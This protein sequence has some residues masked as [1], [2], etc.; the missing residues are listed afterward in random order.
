MRPRTRE[1][2][3]EDYE[4]YQ[5]RP[6]RYLDTTTPPAYHPTVTRTHQG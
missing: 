5:S 3:G 4:S 6:A 1:A 2:S